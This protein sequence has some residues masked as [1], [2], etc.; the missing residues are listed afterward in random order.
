M[1]EVCYQ[2]PTT[3]QNN[4]LGWQTCAIAVVYFAF[5]IYTCYCMRKYMIETKLYKPA[6]VLFYVSSVATL[7]A[8]ILEFCAYA[9][10][11]F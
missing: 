9:S 1:S 10:S 2:D 6:V 8:R 4:I 3:E 5:L 7:I 11:D